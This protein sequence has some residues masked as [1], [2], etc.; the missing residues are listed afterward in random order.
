[1]MSGIAAI[2]RSTF[3]RLFS[4]TLDAIRRDNF[5]RIF[6]DLVGARPGA[7]AVS[8]WATGTGVGLTEMSIDTGYTVERHGQLRFSQGEGCM[9]L[10]VRFDPD[11]PDAGVVELATRA[12]QSIPAEEIDRH[13]AA[14]AAIFDCV[15]GGELPAARMLPRPSVPFRRVLYDAT[16]PFSS[17][18][19]TQGRLGTFGSDR[20][21]AGEVAELWSQLKILIEQQ[22]AN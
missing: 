21:T 4:N 17:W 8:I 18:G 19:G 5:G 16:V 12:G 6:K 15:L 22:N 2:D 1:M 13:V 10:A 3:D 7:R 11:N 14:V 9:E 20:G